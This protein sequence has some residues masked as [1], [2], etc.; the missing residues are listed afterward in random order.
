MTVWWCWSRL[1][2][3]PA[4]EFLYSNVKCF[5]YFNGDRELKTLTFPISEER[6]KEGNLPTWGYILSKNKNEI[7]I[8]AYWDLYSILKNLIILFYLTVKRSLQ[9]FISHKACLWSLCHGTHWAHQGRAC[10][11]VCP[12]LEMHV[13]RWHWLLL[14]DQYTGLPCLPLDP[15]R[16]NIYLHL[17]SC[18]PLLPA[19]L[20]FFYFLRLEPLPGKFLLLL[21][22][23]MPF[24]WKPFISPSPGRFR[25][26]HASTVLRAF[27]SLQCCA[28]RCFISCLAAYLPSDC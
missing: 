19:R 12:C 9:Y 23:A 16:T 26:S 3:Q 15:L 24:P 22:L 7:K 28:V 1:S 27:S 18:Y 11:Q 20:H 4:G 25:L 10:L 2:L 14:L 8:S 21:S 6:V 5:L 13:F 17:G